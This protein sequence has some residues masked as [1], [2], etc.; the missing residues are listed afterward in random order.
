MKRE[1][2]SEDSSSQLAGGE[3][4]HQARESGKRLCMKRGTVFI[5]FLRGI[6]CPEKPCPEEE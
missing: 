2:L 4:R 6:R 5:L 1:P 3:G